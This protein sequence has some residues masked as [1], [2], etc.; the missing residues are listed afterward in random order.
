VTT[1]AFWLVIARQRGAVV[2]R[3][4]GALDV[5]ES[6]RL[7]TI[8]LDLIDGQG[9]L[10]VTVDLRNLRSLDL[11][12]LKVFTAASA[13][14]ARRGGTL[15]LTGPA[16]EFLEALASAGLTRLIADTTEA[17]DPVAASLRILA[18]RSRHPAGRALKRPKPGKI[19]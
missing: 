1:P 11:T 15:S 3:L 18:S 14:L 8:L 12:G 16:T 4:H 10:A 9:N 13:A 5:Q 19:A 6:G 7:A 2:V 17:Q